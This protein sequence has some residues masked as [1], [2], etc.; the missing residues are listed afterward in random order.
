LSSLGRYSTTSAISPAFFL[1]Y[2]L[3]R[4]LWFCLGQ[5]S[6]PM[7]LLT[8]TSYV[9]GITVVW[10]H[11][12][13]LGWGGVWLSFCLDWPWISVLLSAS[14]VAGITSRS[15]QVHHVYVFLETK[16][17]ALLMLNKHLTTKLTPP[18]LEY[19][20]LGRVVFTGFELKSSQ[21]L[22]RLFYHLSHTFSS[23]E[24]P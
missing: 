11:T 2:F 14:L 12:R 17:R 5:A 21:W 24:Y 18:S 3:G 1:L 23:L 19:F 15:H 4:V 9:P 10:H 13:L 16:P 6:D 20:F 7:I 8:S 22:G